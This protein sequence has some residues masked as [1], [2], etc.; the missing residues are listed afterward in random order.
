MRRLGVIKKFGPLIDNFFGKKIVLID[1]S[2][3]R[4]NT[5][6]AI[7]ALLKRCGAREVSVV[8]ACLVA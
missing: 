5:V 8:A 2:I 7:V 3:V 6:T 4:G 1:D